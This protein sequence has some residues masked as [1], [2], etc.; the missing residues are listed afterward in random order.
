MRLPMIARTNRKTLHLVVALA[1]LPPAA[2]LSVADGGLVFDIAGAHLHDTGPHDDAD[3][4]YLMTTV[5][6]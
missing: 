6:F 3:F 1:A 2:S 5:K 4:G